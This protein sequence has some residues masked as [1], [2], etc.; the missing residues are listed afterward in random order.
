[1]NLVR[2]GRIASMLILM[3]AA[4][5]AEPETVTTARIR[6]FEL[7][8][9]LPGSPIRIRGVITYRR[10]DRRYA[11]LQDSTGAVFVLRDKQS[12]E[13]QPGQRVEI[14]GEIVPG[15]YAYSVRER[16]IH[17]LGN[18]PLPVPLRPTFEDLAASENHCRWVEV[19][20][21]VRTATFDKN[22]AFHVRL[23]LG[24]GRVHA[25]SFDVREGD[26][27]GLPGAR[28]R[29]RGA[30]GGRSNDQRQL[31]MP[32]IHFGGISAIVVERPAE[33]GPGLSE[34]RPIN[35][36]FQFKPGAGETA[37]VRFAGAVTCRES[38]RA[39]F[40]DDGTGGVRVETVEE[41]DVT[42][43]DRVEA[44]GFSV[45]G[46]Q[47]PFV[48][49]STFRVVGRSVEP[50]PIPFDPA[51]AADGSYDNRLVSVE[52]GLLDKKQGQAQ[53]TLLLQAGS[54]VFTAH[55]PSDPSYGWAELP[56]GSLL[57]ATGVWTAEYA[58]E[59]TLQPVPRSF[60]LLL[61]SPRDLVI[62][63]R[64]S[65]W[66]AGRLLGLVA[67]LSL[68][69]AMAVAWVWTLGRKVRQQTAVIH[70]KVER[71]AVFE[72]RQRIARDFHDTLQQD[73]VG[74]MMQ[75]N[76][77]SARMTK[78]PEAA[79]RSL[80]FARQLLRRSIEEIRTAVW[81]LR[82]RPLREGALPLALAAAMEARYG[83]DS[84]AS[85]EVEG[86]P[87]KLPTQ[88]ETQFLRIAEEAVANA[89]KHSDATSIR[90]ELRYSDK[91]LRLRVIDNGRG[92]DPSTVAAVPGGAHF[93]LISMRER[94][95]KA[96]GSFLLR[97]TQGTGTEIEIEAALG[98]C[99]G[100]G[101]N[102]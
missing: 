50:L 20:G 82:S 9:R 16:R 34:L 10:A 72:E 89:V 25:L 51:K 1:M 90:V 36:L 48:E 35:S 86:E 95:E 44:V 88:V 17:I 102:A 53:H 55:L 66:T 92:F 7:E 87:R 60:Q 98:E 18:G 19:R 62:L 91:F 64:P 67:A 75:I 59:S 70:G 57:R 3:L 77:S 2:L 14:E 43:G 45:V 23:S 63:A 41:A 40:L 6:Q 15:Q 11:F 81:D 33:S 21:M 65:W 61:R 74:V 78:S 22:G 39:F 68:C 5:G 4:A 76:A 71:E 32:V 100:D 56:V 27:A 58:L 80:D 26:A 99:A 8:K 46:V 37:R 83:G 101:L 69:T 97:S 52:V 54:T 13:I 24:G 30:L 85:I 31:V 73:L 49:D 84:P 94:A 96:G 42:P 29:I 38:D 28:V 93:G 79:S 47:R 12:L